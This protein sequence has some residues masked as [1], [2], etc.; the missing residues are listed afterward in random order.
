MIII[1]E[2][3]NNHS[4]SLT[5]SYSDTNIPNTV[6]LVIHKGNATVILAGT[7]MSH[8][9]KDKPQKFEVILKIIH[10]LASRYQNPGERV[11]RHG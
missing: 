4:I 11:R 7:Y 10:N 3:Y 6:L 9:E 1:N 8:E 5:N 2:M